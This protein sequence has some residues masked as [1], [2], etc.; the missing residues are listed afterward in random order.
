MRLLYYNYEAG[1]KSIAQT[2]KRGGL[3]STHYD[4]ELPC[5]TILSHT[6]GKDDQEILYK[7]VKTRSNGMLKKAGYKKLEFC[8]T[9][10]NRDGLKYFWIYTCCIKKSDSSELIESLNSTFRWYKGASRCYVYLE[11]IATTV[12]WGDA[13]NEQSQWEASF[14]QHPWFARGWTLQEL[15]APP[16]AFYTS[17]YAFLGNK[18][19]VTMQSLL[20][21]ITGIRVAALR[22]VALSSFSVEERRAWAS[23][24]NTRRPE[25]LAYCML[26]IFDVFLPF[27]YGFGKELDIFAQWFL[28]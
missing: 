26:G 25:D 24:R 13:T 9:L 10:A 12:N 23:R 15:L 17:D 3:R 16:V 28:E 5:Y 11:G 27:M 18:R 8:S 1:A 2:Q 4:D 21:D 14:R 22:G 19:S 7:D 6:W 20:R